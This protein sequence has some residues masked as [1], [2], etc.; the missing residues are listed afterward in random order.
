MGKVVHGINAPLVTCAVVDFLLDPV[1]GG[2][3]EE[4]VLVGHVD[5]GP[6]HALRFAKFPLAHAFE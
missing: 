4:E 2:V 3:P 6:Q 1:Q 5:L